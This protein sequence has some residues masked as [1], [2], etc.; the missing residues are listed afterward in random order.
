M[1]VTAP[2]LPEALFRTKK[3]GTLVII[4]ATLP[5]LRE[6]RAGVIVTVTVT[7][8]SSVTLKP[9]PLVGVYRASK[10]AVNALTESLAVEAEP[11]GVRAHLVP[12]G[13]SP[14]TRF[15]DTV[16]SHLRGLNVP[17][18]A[19]LI[20]GFAAAAR[21]DAGPVTHAHDVAEAVWRAVTDPS[22]PFRIPAGADADADAWMA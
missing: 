14:E 3:P 5:R 6:R 2:E 8:T 22:A 16:R 13:R 12:P 9:L 20:Q 19:P 21:N 18:Y 15:G 4:Q 10:A 11:F 7:V 1:E 17:D